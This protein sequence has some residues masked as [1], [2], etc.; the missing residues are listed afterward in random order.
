MKKQLLCSFFCF[1]LVSITARSQTLLP[2]NF[3]KQALK[4]VKYLDDGSEK[5]EDKHKY[6]FPTVAN[7][8]K[9][10]SLP[11]L[12]LGTNNIA[13]NDS[14]NNVSMYSEI[15][16]DYL[17][18]VRVSIGTTLS[19]SKTDSS[20]QVQQK[21][22]RDKFTQRFATGGGSLI[23]NFCLP[24]FVYPSNQFNAAVSLTPKFSLEPPS[25]GVTSG[26]FAHNTSLGSD[27]QLGL[28]GIKDLIS[29]F[30]YMRVAYTLGNTSFYDA[31]QLKDNDRKPFWINTYTIGVNVKDVFSISYQ[32]FFGSPTVTNM[33]RGNLT[34]T[35]SP[36]YR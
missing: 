3:F 35:I 6:L 14:T 8:K 18:P 5:V 19:F 23:F 33:L 20:A 36:N 34:F 26:S 27:I 29:F 7:P 9:F 13:Y 28:N 32:K 22:N 10:E 24:V 17:G 4:T 12:F 31:L 15:V 30:G 21:L 1:L 25:F 11:I 16:A 2:N